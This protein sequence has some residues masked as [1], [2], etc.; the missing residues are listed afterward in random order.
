[1]DAALPRSTPDEIHIVDRSF[2][3]RDR[4]VERPFNDASVHGWLDETVRQRS[5][6]PGAAR[7]GPVLPAVRCSFPPWA[8]SSYARL[9]KILY[10]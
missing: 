5:W 6:R 2:M 9:H 3:P 4:A 8:G 10:V 7:A 1:M